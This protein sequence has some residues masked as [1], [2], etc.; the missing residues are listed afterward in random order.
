MEI[1]WT[2]IVSF[3]YGSAMVYALHE[4][5]MD[6]FETKGKSPVIML[7]L[8][9]LSGYSL[10][11]QRCPEIA[12]YRDNEQEFGFGSNHYQR[13]LYF[14]ALAAIQMAFEPKYGF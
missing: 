3:L 5:T 9:A 6:K 14:V 7:I 1:V 11:S 4:T 12:I 10:F 8:I 13:Q 2:L